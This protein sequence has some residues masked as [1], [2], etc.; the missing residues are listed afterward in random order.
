M[1]AMFGRTHVCAE[2]SFSFLKQAKSENRNR[3]A[4]ETLGDSLQL[5]T[6]NILVLIWER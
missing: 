6:N 1:H 4:H 2:R 5:A 3:N